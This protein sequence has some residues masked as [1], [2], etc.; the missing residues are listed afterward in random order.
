MIP[1]AVFIGI[2]FSAICSLAV[3]IGVWIYLIKK[4]KTKKINR[5]IL[6]GLFGFFAAEIIVREPILMIL[7]GEAW[8]ADFA[9]SNGVLYNL[10]LSFTVAIA[11]TAARFLIL[12]FAVKDEIG[13][14][15]GLGTGFG[16]GACETMAYTGIV[17]V[18]NLMVCIMIYT[19]S[20]GNT[21]AYADIK[22]TLTSQSPS[23]YFAAGAERVLAIIIHIGLSV[24]LAYFIKKGMAAAGFAV[25]MGAHCVYDFCVK[26]T[27]QSGA[28]VWV[29]IAA[30]TVF[31][32]AFAA[33][34]VFI[35]K[36]ENAET[37]KIVK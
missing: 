29:T 30:M 26:L 7:G 8:F 28:S 25:C 34:A 11:E 37:P 18:V 17:S 24:I 12:K 10:F 23:V 13:F 14:T 19:N 15:A 36:K 32:A 9:N 16:H 20:L 21:E 3:P 31:A 6:L 1:T 5:Y 22:N 27:A 33:A 35:R 2:L 4:D